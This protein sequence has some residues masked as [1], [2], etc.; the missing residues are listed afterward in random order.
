MEWCGNHEDELE[1][2]FPPEQAIQP[3][4][5]PAPGDRQVPPTVVPT[6]NPEKA[7]SPHHEA[8]DVVGVVR[9]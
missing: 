5:I 7:T 3:G 1:L 4:D 8:Q 6:A 2:T 9:E